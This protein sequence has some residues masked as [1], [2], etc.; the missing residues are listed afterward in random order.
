MC[1]YT[2]ISHKK[3]GLRMWFRDLEHRGSRIGRKLMENW[4]VRG[5][6]KRTSEFL[7]F[8]QRR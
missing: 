6:R 2:V 3:V 8:F 7:H 1:T 4:G 5:K